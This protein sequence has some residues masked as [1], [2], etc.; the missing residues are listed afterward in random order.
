MGPESGTSPLILILEFDTHVSIYPILFSVE[1]RILG[2]QAKL[3]RYSGNNSQAIKTL[4]DGLSPERPIHFQQADAMLV[5]EV[6]WIYLAERRFEES[7]QMFLRMQTLNNWLVVEC[8][9]QFL[10]VIANQLFLVLRSHPTYSYIAAGEHYSE[11]HSPSYIDKT[12]P[13]HKGCYLSLETPEGRTKARQQLDRL[14]ALLERKK[15]GGR[16]LPTEIFI[17][18]KRT[19]RS[20]LTRVV[21]S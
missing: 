15:I 1:T 13:Y 3:Q 5:F 8:S 17:R 19:S 14:P 4:V 16:D 10:R 20:L 6:A 9:I 2:R 18:K 21:G 7:A 12:C 11:R